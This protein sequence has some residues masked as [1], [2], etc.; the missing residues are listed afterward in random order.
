MARI[1]KYAPIVDTHLKYYE[2]L[3][4]DNNPNSEYFKISEF[5]DT[6]TAGKN[7]FLIEGSPYLMETTEIKIEILDV[8]GN[9]I[10][11]EPGHG[12]P[13]YYEGT[14]KIVAIYVYEDTPI[15]DANITVLGELKKYYN[16]NN[17]L[18]D[19]PDNWKGIYNVKWQKNFK[20]NRLLSNEDKVRFYKRPKVTIDELVKPLYATVITN[21]LQSGS[22]SGTPVTP[23]QG[24]SLSGYT[25][26]TYYKLTTDGN[27]H[28]T[29]SIVGNTLELTDLNY[30]PLGNEV[31]SSTDLLV[32]TPYTDTNGNVTSFTGQRYTASFS[33]LEGT[34]LAASALT[35]SFAKI[36]LT[37]LT[38]FTGDVARVKI[39][40]KSQSDIGDYQFVQEVTLESNE[41]LVNLNS[42][43]SISDYYGIFTQPLLQQYWV[44][45]SNSLVE[46]FNQAYLYDSA[47]LDNNSGVSQYFFTTQS[48]S[49]NNGKEYTLSF[50]LR[51]EA[52]TNPNNYIRAFLSGS[53]SG[54]TNNT[55]G[56]EQTITQI[57]SQDILLQ[58]STVT[59]NITANTIQNPKLYF[60]VV[61]TGWHIANVSFTSAQE[62]AFSPDEITFIQSVPRSLPIETFDYRFEFYDINNN[63]IPV[64]VEKQ[65]LFNGGN[66]QTLNKS[67]KLNPS[68][69]YFQFDSGSNP[70][71]PTSI[72]FALTKTLLTSS[73]VNFTSQSVD[74]NG[75]ILS[76]SQYTTGD[77][78][79]PGQLSN[80]TGSV[81]YMTVQHFT[82]SNID[83]QVQYVEIT[84]ECEGYT[85][86]AV[87]TRVLDGF[88][89]VNHIIRPYQGTE[90]RN[91]ST[92]SLEI[93]AITVDGVNEVKLRSNLPKGRSG[94][95]LHVL[96]GS[97]YL[98]ISAATASGFLTGVTNGVLGTGELDYN[99]I[100]TR[101]TLK[102]QLNK[103]LTVY[104]MPTASLTSASVLTSV[105]L[106]DLQD[107]LGTGFLNYS[108]EHFT[109]QPRTQTLFTP[110]SASATASFYIRGKNL[111]PISASILVYP[112]MSI[113]TDFQPHY[114]LYYATQSVDPNV[115]I[116]A[117]DDNKLNV[118]SGY[119]EYA[120][121]TNDIEVG[122]LYD[123]TLTNESRHLNITFTY[124]EPYTTSSVSVSKTWQIVPEGKP[125]DETIIFE[126]TPSSVI[127]NSNAKGVIKTYT[128]AD[129]EIKLKQGAKYLAFS[130]SQSPG[131]FN[132]VFASGSNITT[133]SINFNNT[134]S[135]LMT[136]MSN[137]SQLSGSITYD[138]EIH[139]YFTSSYY[140]QSYV[141]N[142]T[143]AVDAA[144]AVQ[145]LITPA[146][147]NLS[148]NQVGIINNYGPANTI[149]KLR[150][151]ND[152]LLYTASKEPGTFQT[153]SIQTNHITVA[154]LTGSLLD[155]TT[156]IV[157]G[158]ASMDSPSASI[159]YNF[160]VYPYSL[161]SGHTT[162]SIS[163]TGSQNFLRTKDGQASRTLA[164]SSTSTT[165]NFDGDGVQVSPD[166]NVILTVTPTNFTGSVYYQF[167]K[168]GIAYTSPDI[169]NFLEIGS[170]DATSPGQTAVWK[171]EGR[172]GAY[173]LPVLAS[174]EVTIM[175]IKAGGDTYNTILT[176]ENSS[177]VYKVSGE[178]KFAGSGTTIK[179]FKGST[180]L[181]HVSTYDN[182]TYDIS[183]NYIGSLG[184]YQVKLYSKPSFVTLAGSLSVGSILPTVGG[185]AV[186]GNI[187]AWDYPKTN[188]TAT[189]VYQINLEDGRA[190]AFKTQSLSIQYEG[191]TGPGIVMRGTYDSATNYIG[192][193]ETTNYR[194]D[195]VIY[196]TNPTTYYA[197]ASGS[198]PATTAGVHAPSGTTSDNA[199]WQYLGTQDFFVSAK[200]AIFD[201]SYVKNT[202]NVGTYADTSK[203]ANVI[204]AG[205][206]TDPYIAIGQHGTYGTGGS[207]YSPTDPAIIGYGQEGIYLGIYET[208]VTNG[209]SGRFSI[210]NNDGTKALLWDGD[211][212]TIRGSIRQ[213]AAGVPEGRVLGP[214]V[215]GYAY[216][217]NDIVTNAG[218]TW[219][220][221]NAHTSGASTEPFVGASYAS[222]WTLAA[223]AGTSGTAG[224]AGSGGVNGAAGADGPGVVFR[225]LYD[226]AKVYYKSSTRT[227]VVKY[228]S[229]GSNYWMTNNASLNNSSGSYWL[230]PSTSNANWISFGAEFSS[231]AT[232]TI[233]SE[234]STVESTLNIGTNPTGNANIAL[235]GGTD[236]PYISLGQGTQGYGK[237]GIFIGNESNIFKISA[238]NGSS[239]TSSR[240]LRWT[241]NGLDLAGNVT[242]FTGKIGDWVF[243]GPQISSANN[244]VILDAS[245]ESVTVKDSSDAIRFIA[246]TDSTLPDVAT[247]VTPKT[248]S[249][250]TGQI[251]YQES[252]DANEF[253]GGTSYA[254]GSISVGAGEG[255]K[256]SVSYKYDP[257]GSGWTNSYVKSR[258]G[259][260]YGSLYVYLV[261][262]EHSDMSSP[263]AVSTS[264]AVAAARGSQVYYG[265]GGGLPSVVSNTEI[266]LSDGSIKLAKDI[267]EGEDILSWNGIDSFVKAKI[268]KIKSRPVPFV[269]RLVCGGNEV[270]VS[271]SHKF[272]ADGD[273]EI[274]VTDLIA[275]VSKI[276]VKVGNTIEL[277]IVDS[278]ELVYEDD[279]VYTFS[280][281]TYHNYISNLVISHNS[282]PGDGYWLFN[283]ESMYIADPTN[284]SLSTTL[285]SST[286][287]YIGLRFDW[288][289][290]SI[291]TATDEYYDYQ[292]T[293]TKI[294]YYEPTGVILA[295]KIVAGTFVNGGGFAAVDKDTRYIRLSNASGDY[296]SKG[297]WN[298]LSA[299]L[300]VKGALWLRGDI[301]DATEKGYGKVFTDS[302]YWY[303]Y[304]AG[305]KVFGTINYTSSGAAHQADN[306]YYTITNSYN[307]SSA[308]VTGGGKYLTVFFTNDIG[309]SNYN[310]TL[311]PRFGTT[312]WGAT[313]Q[314]LTKTQTGFTFRIVDYG[315]GEST[316]GSNGNSGTY[317]DFQ[318]MAL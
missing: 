184:Q 153:S 99:A 88:G 238:D 183:G 141:Q 229:G 178:L 92:Q 1:K 189:I 133:G 191:A 125:G 216:L 18:V 188:S 25:L 258:G 234:Y 68:S 138:L 166:G 157:S 212:L 59:Q 79:Y 231:I 77:R 94:N 289:K 91:S 124:T 177:L 73:I 255:G 259:N 113:D 61:G 14:S 154:T 130:G 134:S 103:Q 5:K 284:I 295:E 2:T 122:E 307:A 20:V 63:F 10:Y 218:R 111:E 169:S 187:I 66:L 28:W 209:T 305:I 239:G 204:I 213:T 298:A 135:L 12:I 26:P 132:I 106:T 75:N 137:L 194:R 211:T 126:V 282:M 315:S 271:D 65:K 225:G 277:K 254:N 150:E 24:Q 247:S 49:V 142:Y 70:V 21:V 50:N 95:Q 52:N 230:A 159:Q 40:R 32:T 181:T 101:D 123:Y 175:G 294:R 301:T 41:L 27:T 203:F 9:P 202:L 152:Y 269:Y 74:F 102:A 149:I 214:W 201:E 23:S 219:T 272:W 196:G 317:V 223:D 143:K 215:T 260:G 140:T 69:L 129:T 158:F 116:V 261:V 117:I 179:A 274:P 236:Y 7:A 46:T 293:Y 86:T 17:V 167:F 3:V 148:G 288:Y 312:G 275:G 163:V 313:V 33:Y 280:V 186:I 309:T 205:G 39:F 245:A 242:A 292:S 185:E 168:D 22:V 296:T 119:P 210:S 237:K 54:S 29:G 151:G 84:G 57:S 243:T 241:G 226:A 291:D 48:L 290:E 144:P 38:T 232:G 276:Y 13:Q 85:D 81:P 43:N 115:A 131:T 246:N 87:I 146:T 256:Y 297:A 268:S 165:V 193:V 283:E 98:N 15:G 208:P 308:A 51:L 100:F 266:I 89:G 302:S 299:T 220:C 200:L 264:Y 206:R 76:G 176:N 72:A 198:G 217:Q 304:P 273:V 270:K 227:D 180:E 4:V 161:L 112:S 262:S 147:V 221:T 78:I 93:Q 82:G 318:V 96:S 171:V 6:L 174:S 263:I 31:V 45:S 155:K 240:Y 34:A 233:I 97:K 257:V 250:G 207:G 173:N 62:T 139:P 228:A 104:L 37:D 16:S 306:T 164:I 55:F 222:Y 195:A 252:I 53:A 253:T 80:I 278:V 71:A 120:Y 199:W 121:Y 44:T 156:L 90:I 192:S 281:P 107:G 235:V 303:G 145:I 64:K 136:S 190:V 197:A 170:G 267:I 300:E 109:I 162:G 128:P 279:I 248:S 314:I 105:I 249:I 11:F 60:E 160:D 286:T 67:F 118:D 110:V 224:T 127:L 244:R 265:G 108:T 114:Y 58:K 311:T 42:Q 83:I 287:Y 36:S 172:D 182:P 56:V 251:F 8:E 30:F 310:V 285:S 316:L 47:K 19:V 35:G